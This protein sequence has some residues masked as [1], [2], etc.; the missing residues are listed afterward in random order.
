M[1]ELFSTHLK[2]RMDAGE[3]RQNAVEIHTP[4]NG[5]IETSI[6][7]FIAMRILFDRT[8]L[9]NSRSQKRGQE[10]QRSNHFYIYHDWNFDIARSST[11]LIE[12]VH[13]TMT[14]S[15]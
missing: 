4:Y 2:R 10:P 6:A 1:E 14:I 5:T 7:E 13:K 9:T 8:A 11:E 3:V 12:M 15:D